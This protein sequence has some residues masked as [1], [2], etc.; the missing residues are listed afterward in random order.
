LVFVKLAVDGK[1]LAAML[2]GALLTVVLVVVDVDVVKE[3]FDGELEVVCEDEDETVEGV[4]VRVVLAIELTI[5][6]L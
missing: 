5:E 3:E 2:F 4:E 1:I 6:F